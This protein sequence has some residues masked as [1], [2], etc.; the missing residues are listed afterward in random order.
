MRGSSY[1]DL[2]PELDPF[3][4]IQI[5]LG[6]WFKLQ[7]D[8]FLLDREMST[9]RRIWNQSNS[10]PFEPLWWG[11]QNCSLV[12]SYLMVRGGKTNY[13]FSLFLGTL[14]CRLR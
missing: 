13:I 2:E 3:L 6:G 4:S 12:S 11:D 10:C 9:F 8:F 1:K 14:P 5:P 7:L